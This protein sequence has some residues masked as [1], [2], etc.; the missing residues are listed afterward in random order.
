MNSSSPHSATGLYVGVFA[1]LLLLTALTVGVAFVDLGGLNNA[2]ALA[3]ASVKA[4]LV[5]AIF[6]HV[7]HGL[8]LVKVTIVAALFWLAILIGLTMSDFATRSW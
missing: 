2:A 7:R 6:M 8:T 1:A 5:A 4:A 3:I